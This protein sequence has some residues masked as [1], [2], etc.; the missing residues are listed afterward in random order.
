M[1]DLRPRGSSIFT[2]LALIFFGLLLLTVAVLA[3]LYS[4]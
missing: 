1:A 2:G 3:L 4:R